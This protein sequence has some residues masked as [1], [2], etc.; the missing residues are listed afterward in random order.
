M[1]IALHYVSI[2]E[3]GG[4]VM[5]GSWLIWGALMFIGFGIFATAFALNGVAD[6]IRR[7]G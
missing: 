5:D 3:R 6:A 1:G 2:E 4:E 7:H